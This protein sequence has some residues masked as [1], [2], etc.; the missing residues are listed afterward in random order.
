MVVERLG[1][2][3][4]SSTTIRDSFNI[5]TLDDDGTGDYTAHN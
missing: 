1:L 3:Y 4:N 2:T 5:S